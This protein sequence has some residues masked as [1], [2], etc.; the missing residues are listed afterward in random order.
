M[1]KRLWPVILCS[2]LSTGTFIGGIIAALIYAKI[3]FFF[4]GFLGTII[5]GIL[6][7]VLFLKIGSRTMGQIDKAIRMPDA[8]MG[9][10]AEEEKN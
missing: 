9:I 7:I 5:L 8:D 3:S 10:E 6:T 4:Y 1:L 2:V